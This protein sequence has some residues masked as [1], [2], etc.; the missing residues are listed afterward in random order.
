[1][2]HGTSILKYLVLPW[3]QIK[4]GVCADSYFASVRTAEVLMGL[5]FKFIGV[6]KTATKRFPMKYLSD[7]ELTEGRGQ[8]EG[9][10]MK[11]FGRPWIMA[12]VWVDR[13]R[14][15]FI[16]TAST[17]KDGKPYDRIR[18]RQPEPSPE[19]SAAGDT[20]A[21]S[22]QDAICQELTVVQ[23]E[24]CDSTCDAIDQH[25][26]HRQDTLSMERKH[27][28]KSWYKR[29]TSSIFAMYVV[30]AWLMYKGCTTAKQGDEPK[31]TQQEFYCQLAE[32]LIDNNQERVRTRNHSQLEKKCMYGVVTECN[33]IAKSH[34]KEKSWPKGQN[35]KVLCPRSL[36]C[37]H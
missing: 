37:L 7:L 33:T 32:E 22:Q 4:R 24:A 14:Q 21:A 10:V 27:Q 16:S 11:T 26:Q 5:G 8:R 6:V 2:P 25:N 1:M 12:F 3:A 34:Q 19:E 30:D 31:L 29:V 17:L 36:S 15:Y 23:P 35:N 20:E 9:L 13:D 18:W 28:T